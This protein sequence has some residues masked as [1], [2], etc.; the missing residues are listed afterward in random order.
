MNVDPSRV[1]PFGRVPSS[2]FMDKR[3]NA[4][5][6]RVLGI[7]YAHANKAFVCWL[8]LSTLVGLTGID[9][10]DL[11][12]TLRSLEQLGWLHTQ[13]GVGRAKRSMYRLPPPRYLDKEELEHDVVGGEGEA[14]WETAGSLP[15]HNFEM[16]GGLSAKGGAFGHKETGESPIQNRLRTKKEQTTSSASP[17][18]MKEKR[19]VSAPASTCVALLQDPVQKERF[20]RFW[21]AYPKGRGKREAVEAWK[22]IAPDE[23]L[24]EKMLEVLEQAKNSQDWCKNGGQFIP[25]PAKWLESYGWEDD[26]STRAGPLK[27]SKNDKQPSPAASS[28]QGKSSTQETTCSAPETPQRVDNSAAQEALNAMRLAVRRDNNGRAQFG[29]YSP[30]AEEI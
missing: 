26:W 9:R 22:S 25:F 3:L 17:E 6:L 19:E 4:R 13:H 2:V 16:A 28:S 5:H 7:L 10:R 24:I 29:S 18:L 14:G 20:N 12:R 23:T 30:K 11:Q 15:P 21:S 8:Y 27:E 1:P